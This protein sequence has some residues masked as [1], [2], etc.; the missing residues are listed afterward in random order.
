MLHHTATQRPAAGV[1]M[2]HLIDA[3][4]SMQV[5]QESLPDLGRVTITATLEPGQRLRLV[6]FVA[7]GW[8][9]PARSR[10]SAIRS[11]PR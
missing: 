10:R 6:K 7:Y 5:I 9:R 3:P 11:P 4:P 2:E 1:A 8:S